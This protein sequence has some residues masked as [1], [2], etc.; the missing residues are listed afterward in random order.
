MSAKA[1][2]SHTPGPWG[3]E[4]EIR[5]GR[6]GMDPDHLAVHIQRDG[7]SV[8][9]WIEHEWSGRSPNSRLIETAPELFDALQE[10]HDACEFWDNQ[11]DPV[12]VKAR[13]VL[14]RARGL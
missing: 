4:G 3:M 7:W 2:E 14:A 11:D 8:G 12:L 5:F 9:Y 1:I 10:L 13:A 6:I